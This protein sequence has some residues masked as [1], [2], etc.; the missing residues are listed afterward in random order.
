MSFQINN[1]N[2]DIKKANFGLGSEKVARE[3]ITDNLAQISGKVSAFLA[4]F[5]RS[6][7]MYGCSQQDNKVLMTL[8]ERDIIVANRNIVNDEIDKENE[9]CF[10]SFLCAINIKN[11]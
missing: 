1:V 9:N 10:N 3:F 7:D 5:G 2:L 8:Q 6:I 4:D 11:K